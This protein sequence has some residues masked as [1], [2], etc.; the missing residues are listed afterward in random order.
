MA[1]QGNL[2]GKPVLSEGQ[3]LP[4]GH[5]YCPVATLGDNKPD[6]G[7]VSSQIQDDT[8]MS[9]SEPSLN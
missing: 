6:E 3:K 1:L 7:S 5:C 4:W 2:P 9:F 8:H